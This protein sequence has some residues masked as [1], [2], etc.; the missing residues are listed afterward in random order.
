MAAQE[1]TKSIWKDLN[2]YEIDQI[3]AEAVVRWNEKEPLYLSGK[4]ADAAKE[5][6]EAHTEESAKAGL[7]EEYLNRLLP[8]DWAKKTSVSED[9]SSTA[10]TLEKR[11]KEQ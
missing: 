9:V 5:A 11:T 7:I 4:L 2:Q 1:R 10:A 6:Q 8:E 3:W